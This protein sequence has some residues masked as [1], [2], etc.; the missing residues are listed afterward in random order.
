MSDPQVVIKGVK[1][2]LSVPTWLGLV[3]ATA[4]IVALGLGFP[5]GVPGEWVW[6]P[7]A[8]MNFNPI[9]TG[10]AA[11]MLLALCGFAWW[12]N[13]EIKRGGKKIRPL[14]VL[15]IF[16]AVSFR[17]L[18]AALVPQSQQPVPV[19]WALV[20]L[21]PVA[22]SF[23]DEARNL[24]QQGLSDYLRHYHEQLPTKPF[25]ASTHPPGLPILFA[26][27]RSLAMHPI[28]QSLA[29]IDENSLLLAREIYTRIA[30]PMKPNSVYPSDADFKASWWIALF[31][32]LCGVGAV[33]IWIWML[34]QIN[35]NPSAA[36]FASVTPATL[37]WQMTVDNI[38]LFITTATFASS[39]CWQRNRQWTWA[40]LT[41]LAAGISLWLAFK[42]AIPLACIAL[43]LVWGNLKGEERLP[44]AQ[45]LAAFAL[46]VSPYFLAWLVFG[47][48]PLETFKAASAAHHA[49]AGA[50]ARAYLPWL[51]F[52]LADFGMA[53]GGAWF[54]FVVVRL[55]TWWQRE[56]WQP[57][58]SVTTFLVL[59]LLDLTGLMRGEVARLWM[60]FIPLLT[61]ETARYIPTNPR[62]TA[63]L[64]LLQSG[65]G[66]AL[67]IHLEFLRPF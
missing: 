16:L 57:S 44:V 1:V 67:H 7:R 49:Q 63:L 48:Q 37:W 38:H 12:A 40:I 52:N 56:R 6:E 19:F 60:P 9:L 30:P 24:E 62:E 21:S 4:V 66:L 65:V 33:L 32:F 45:M 54:G 36:I 23:Y 22:T 43:W 47:F 39:F 64:V 18:I 42:N 51:L 55:L 13:G 61:F 26:V 29:P 15:S 17:V 10:A 28:L 35:P 5:F 31:C 2:R 8:E 46:A 20:I 3:W 50:H 53:L 11:A 41:G 25:H 58:I 14:L 34:W 27:W 59:M